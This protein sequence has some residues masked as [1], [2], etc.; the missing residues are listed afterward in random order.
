MVLH[1]AF[2]EGMVNSVAKMGN[3][4][5]LEIAFDRVGTKKLM[6][7]YASQHMHKQA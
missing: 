7:N 6:A 5:M 1:D 4:A 3:D 2:G